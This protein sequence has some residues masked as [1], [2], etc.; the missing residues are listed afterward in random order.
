M[1]PD[2]DLAMADKNELADV[3]R[4]ILRHLVYSIQRKLAQLTLMNFYK[5]TG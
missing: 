5:S 3:N 4:N 1:H 2:I